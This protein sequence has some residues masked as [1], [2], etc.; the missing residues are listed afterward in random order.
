MK[1]ELQELLLYHILPNYQPASGFKPGPLETLLMGANLTVATDPLMFDSSGV[2]DQDT[3]VCNGIIHSLESVLMP[4]DSDFCDDFNFNDRR[5]LQA[6]SLNCTGI[7]D[8]ARSDPNLSTALTLIEAA[9][10]APMFGCE[11]PFTA[12]IPSNDAFT[13]LSSESLVL[14]TDPENVDLL[15]HLLLYH[16]LPGI[17][18]SSSFTPGPVDTL[19]SDKQVTVQVAPLR[20]DE[21]VVIQADTEACQGIVH[22]L[23]NVL[24]PFGIPTPPQTSGICDDYTFD[25]RTRQ[26]QNGGQ[27][28]D[29]NILDVA[30][31][32]SDLTIVTTL[33]DVAGL[34][35]V[36]SCAGPFTGIFPSNTAFDDVPSAFLDDLLLAQNIDRLREFLLY[37]IIPG[38]MLTSQFVAGPQDTLATDTIDVTLNPLEFNG[39]DL[40][41]ADLPACNGYV[42]IVSGLLNP[43]RECSPVSTKRKLT[44]HTQ[45]R[46]IRRP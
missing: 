35:S 28:C 41:N 2:I 17:S 27:D 43:F 11:G 18:Q 25:R 39:F 29:R 20:F 5:N 13:Q 34:T 6:N 33:I 1:D 3:E 37:H 42:N 45:K 14:L 7:L 38:A 9:G 36:F 4:P 21:S 8:I 10:L 26:L 32:N 19:L 23:D 30:R 15:R 12:L 16:M 24:F 40:F 46:L 31:Q 22:V 44:I